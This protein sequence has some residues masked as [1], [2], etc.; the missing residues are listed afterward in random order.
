MIYDISQEIFSAEIYPGDPMPEK[1]EI[2]SLHKSVPDKC[3]LTE[4]KLG[5]HTGTHIDAPRHFIMDGIDVEN[6]SLEKC[7][8]ICKVITVHG[9]LDEKIIW[10]VAKE[11]FHKILIKGEVCLDS[12]NAKCI[13]DA[14]I[15]CIGVE[16]STV[17]SG[18]EQENVHK[19][20]LGRGVVIIEGLRMEEVTDGKYFLS[21]LPLK[22][23]G[24]DG[25][26]VRA[27]LWDV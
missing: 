9:R 16:G 8:G 23:D 27:V 20:L 25:S 18:I 6:V 12:E 24:L 17:G 5:S 13:V 26:P 3:Q 1:K 14:G 19:I 21:A 2:L 11:G 22:M 7:L 4:L 15:H 10:E